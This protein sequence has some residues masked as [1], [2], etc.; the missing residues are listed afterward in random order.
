MYGDDG[1]DVLVG[2][3]G[4]DYLKGGEGEDCYIY[5]F[6]DG[7]DRINNY[8]KSSKRV[9]DRLVFGEGIAPEDIMV[10]RS[11]YHLILENRKNRET[12]RIYRAFYSRDY[13]LENIEFA[14]GTKW[15]YETIQEMLRI[16]WGTEGDDKLY[17]NRSEDGYNENE[18]FYAGA[19]NDYIYA[20]DGND[21]LY[22][23]AGN[24][25]NSGG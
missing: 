21:I 5:N 9:N 22:G 1:D 11:G 16:Q 4:N 19:G 18:K 2:G 6:G 10:K 15:D 12:I 7:N 24:A 20:G 23:E 8:D 17:G 3:A 14:D 13:F 25:E